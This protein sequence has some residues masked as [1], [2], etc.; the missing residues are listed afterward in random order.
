MNQ[1]RPNTG[2]CR[3][4]EALEHLYE[5][6]DSELPDLDLVRLRAHIDECVTCLQAVS[7]ETELR[8]VLKRSCAEVAPDALRMRVMTQLSLLRTTTTSD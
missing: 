6:V 4:E 5:Y 2:E 3:C 8:V 7:A 1:D